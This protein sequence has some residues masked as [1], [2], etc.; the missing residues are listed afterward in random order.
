MPAVLMAGLPGSG[1]TTLAQSLATQLKGHVLNK[2]Q[3]RLAI[4]GPNQVAYTA[5]QDDLIQTFML[6]AADSLWAA[7][8]MLWILFDGRTYSRACQ[9]D[10]V[11]ER[12]P[13]LKILF[14]TAG[15]S[16]IRKRL[17]EPHPAANRNWALYLK[18]RDNFEPISEP[19]C[20][21]NTDITP[22]LS[23]QQALTYLTAAANT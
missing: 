5:S 10:Q 3:I 22:D 2:D 17:L 12:I 21:I 9:R 1:K 15:E 19:H 18:V 11:R 14:C 4:F 7:D 16:S 23:L 6:D 13:N 20:I 8:P